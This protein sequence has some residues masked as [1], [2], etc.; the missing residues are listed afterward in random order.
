MQFAAIAALVLYCQNAI[1]RQVSARSCEG[2][3]APKTATA[4]QE[5][6]GGIH[7]RRRVHVA[8][9]FGQGQ[10]HR[11]LCMVY[12]LWACVLVKDT[13]CQVQLARNEKRA[14]KHYTIQLGGTRMRARHRLNP[15]Q[16]IQRCNV[17]DPN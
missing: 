4:Q 15:A 13:I 16:A 11:F 8:E 9:Q 2:F 6:S 1:G 14:G 10:H 5:H 7:Q 12:N 17:N 3:A